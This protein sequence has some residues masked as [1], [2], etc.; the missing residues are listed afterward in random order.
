[1]EG[2]YTVPHVLQ[3]ITPLFLRKID[4][5]DDQCG[6]GFRLVTIHVIK[7]L[8]GFFAI[9]GHQ[10]VG[11]DLGRMNGFPYQEDIRHVVFH[12]Q[13]ADD[14]GRAPRFRRGG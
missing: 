4:I 7:K 12:D 11:L 8:G 6:A 5:E 1:L 3:N 2:Q 14:L 13:D 10:D 9:T